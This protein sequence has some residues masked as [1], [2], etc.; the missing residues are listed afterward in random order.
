MNGAKEGQ[1]AVATIERPNGVRRLAPDHLMAFLEALASGPDGCS[2]V[3]VIKAQQ[4][5]DAIVRG[6][7]YPQTFNGWFDNP[8]SLKVH[9]SLLKDVSAYVTVNPIHRDL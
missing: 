8:K 9:A 4:D 5:G 3:R 1:A 6:K 2:E 7:K